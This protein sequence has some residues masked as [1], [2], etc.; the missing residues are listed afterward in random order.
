MMACSP[1]TGPC[2]YYEPGLITFVSDDCP[3][4]GRLAGLQEERYELLRQ[5]R[6]KQDRVARIDAILRERKE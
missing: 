2:V 1:R 5:I 3:E 6:E 4:H